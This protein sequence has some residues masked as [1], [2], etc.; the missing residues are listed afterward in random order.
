[1]LPWRDKGQSKMLNGKPVLWSGYKVDVAVFWKLS[2][3]KNLTNRPFS[4]LLLIFLIPLLVIATILKLPTSSP[5]IWS[6]TMNHRSVKAMMNDGLIPRPG[7][8]TQSYRNMI[9]MLG[10][11]DKNDRDIYRHS[12]AKKI[13]T[14]QAQIN[15][16]SSVHCVHWNLSGCMPWYKSR[17]NWV[18]LS[19][20]FESQSLT[21]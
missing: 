18:I 10:N 4:P 14:L 5:S 8:R 6:G 16:T 9:N 17:M 1:M 20:K 15:P 3:Q 21:Q 11:M 12:S 13:W 19:M 2:G 7:P